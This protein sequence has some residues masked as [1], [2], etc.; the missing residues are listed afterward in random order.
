MSDREEQ[1]ELV[2]HAAD[3]LLPQ[4]TERLARQGLGELE[5]RQGELRL[6]VVA[7]TATAPTVGVSA[8]PG[9]G[10]G[11]TARGRAGGGQHA[12][13]DHLAR[14]S[15]SSS[16][17][18]RSVPGSRSRRATSWATSRCSGSGTTFA[19]PA[20][21]PSTNLV[22]GGRRAGRV[23]PAPGRVGARGMSVAL[24]FSPQGSQ[25]VGMGRALAE[26]SR[27][28][29]DVYR[30]ADRALGWAVSS[31]CWEGPPERL[32][33]TR[34]T[35]PCL[36][37]TSLACLEALREGVE[38]HGEA[39][40]PA[41]VAGHSVGEYAALVAAG[42]GA[43]RGG[44]PARRAAG[45]ADGRRRHRRGHGGGDRAR[46]AGRG[47]GRGRSS[48]SWWSPMTTRPGRS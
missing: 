35:Q 13:G 33:D 10:D 39:L 43:A 32:N 18:M 3:T 34:Q 21:A 15:A 19:R 40:R 47:R 46:P 26:A 38:A 28:A 6:R 24:L 5:I 45:P 42:V 14:R 30:R 1:L 8:R 23:R 2:R 22:L 41:R 36:V 37:T 11:T 9:A 48:T 12:P 27:A 17:P 25:A 31:V 4:L 20:A 16:T 29:R 7:S 44:D